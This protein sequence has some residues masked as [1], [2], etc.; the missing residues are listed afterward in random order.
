M[1][2]LLPKTLPPA[3][4]RRKVPRQCLI[5][6]FKIMWDEDFTVEEWDELNVLWNVPEWAR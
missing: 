1:R 4:D 6:N 2:E 3:N 5:L